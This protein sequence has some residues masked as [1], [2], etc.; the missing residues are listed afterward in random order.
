MCQAHGLGADAH[1]QLIG[2]ATRLP[3]A[4]SKKLESSYGKKLR[5][6]EDPPSSF[7]MEGARWSL[8]KMSV[9]DGALN[10]ESIGVAYT[11]TEWTLEDGTTCEP[12]GVRRA[13]AL[14][15]AEVEEAVAAQALKVR[16]LKEEEGLSNQDAAVSDAVA[17]LK[18]L[19]TLAAAAE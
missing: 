8:D 5:T 6:L 4:M 14:S 11:W 17:E 2:S 7:S 9:V 1:E 10:V 13:R 15:A 18:R 16:R 19:K 3:A 12:G